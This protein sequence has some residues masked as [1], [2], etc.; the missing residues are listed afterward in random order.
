M[1]AT[2]NTVNNNNTPDTKMEQ[3]PSPMEAIPPAPTTKPPPKRNR[4]ATTAERRA[5]HNAVERARR[6]TLNGRFLTLA[7][8]LPPLASIRRPSKS[9]IVGSSIATVRAGRRH[10]LRAA[11]ALKALAREAETL[12]MEVNTWRARARLPVLEAPSRSQDFSIVLSGEMEEDP[13]DAEY[14]IDEGDEEDYEDGLENDDDE[15]GSAPPGSRDG[16]KMDLAATRQHIA[17]P[18]SS[19][20]R[21]PPASES[22]ALM[23]AHA[24]SPMQSASPVTPNLVPHHPSAMN[25]FDNNPM[26]YHHSQMKGAPG[27][28]NGPSFGYD[29]GMGMRPRT[30]E[31]HGAAYDLGLDLDLFDAMPRGGRGGHNGIDAGALG[32]AAS[33][34]AH[35]AFAGPSHLPVLEMP[36]PRSRM[37]AAPYPPARGHPMGYPGYHNQPRAHQ[38]HHPGGL[39]YDDME[40]GHHAFAV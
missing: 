13:A 29:H 22:P 4:R 23:H 12:R 10:R 3:S 26:M 32:W 1:S 20:P 30:A 8:I 9:A 36:I 21:T 34:P 25:H 5:T 37:H 35:P 14:A 11:Q 38:P 39:H 16:M 31:N 28:D 2:N 7:S 19:G 40:F 6:E 18:V 27:Y 17:S 33:N 24:R 15:L